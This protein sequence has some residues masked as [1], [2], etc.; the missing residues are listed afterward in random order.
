MALPD[1]VIFSDVPASVCV[2][3]IAS[4]G[5]QRQVHETEEKLSR[6]REGYV[7][8]CRVLQRDF[9]LP[10]R[11]IDGDHPLETVMAEA[12]DFTREVDDES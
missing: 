12:R 6:L 5:E 3:R 11:V 9:D 8:L 1:A 10:V 4:R 7:A 2:E